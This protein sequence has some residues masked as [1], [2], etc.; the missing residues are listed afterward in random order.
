MRK[1]FPVLLRFSVSFALILILLYI[2]RG[3]YVEI[4]NALKSVN[5]YIF[6]LGLMAFVLAIAVASLR[7][8]LIVAAQGIS[9]NF[10]EALSL[11]F[12]GYFFNNFLPTAIGGDVAKA[13]YLSRKTEDKTGSYTSVFVDRALGLVT[14]IFMAFIALFFV[15]SAVIDKDVRR[16]IYIITA[17]SAAMVAFLA[18]KNLARK[19]SSL[20][21]LV[22]PLEEKLR[23]AYNAINRYRHRRALMLQTIAI[24]II[25]QIFFFTSIGILA[26]SIGSAIVPMQILLRMPIISAMSLLPSINGLGIREGSTVLLFGPLIGQENA[27]AVSILWLAVLFIISIAGGIIYAISPQFKIKIAEI[28]R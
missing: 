1:I 12:I 4:F 2:M 16:M 9:V 13:Y 5:G 26:L 24:S 28:K 22:K 6:F 25:S 27:F 11:T 7:L 21:F 8:K 19:F 3:K 20:L 18:N 14:M 10:F 15:G 23:Q 17:L